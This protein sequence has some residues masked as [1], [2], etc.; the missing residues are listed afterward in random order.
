MVAG[1]GDNAASAVSVNVIESGNAFLSLGTSGVY[2]VADED[3]HPNPDATVHTF[4]H[5]LPNLWHE[6]TVH[7]SAASCLSWLK[8]LLGISDLEPLIQEAKANETDANVPIFL[9]YL[10]GERSPL[11]DP[12]AR[13]VFFGMTHE[14]KAC[15]LTQAVLEGVAFAFA[16]G[17]AAM[18]DAGV[19]INNISVV[20]GGAKNAYWGEILSAALNKSLVYRKA[21]D[22]GGAYG[23]AR[24]AWLAANGGDPRT[25]FQS[26][27]INYVIEP[28]QNR[29]ERLIHK[30]ALFAELYQ[31]LK[32]TFTATYGH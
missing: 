1:G 24:L 18:Y 29:S 22:V 25:V 4:C 8:N 6:M 10:S 14:T 19:N 31:Q 30:Q 23:A 12:Y 11:N 28:N 9:P 20:G 17:Q 32:G 21:A 7:L 5:C 26:L 27:P 3:Y 2:F 13:G 16:Q 15:H